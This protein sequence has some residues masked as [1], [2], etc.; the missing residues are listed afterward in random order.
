[1]KKKKKKKAELDFIKN[2]KKLAVYKRGC[3][4]M[5]GKPETG[6]KIFAKTHV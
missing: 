6:R 4:E 1:M 3:S 5:K 2:F